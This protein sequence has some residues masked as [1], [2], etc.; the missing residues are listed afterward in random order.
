MSK[1]S[2]LLC[3]FVYFLLPAAQAVTPID[4]NEQFAFKHFRFKPDIFNQQNAK[5]MKGRKPPADENRSPL[6]EEIAEYLKNNYQNIGSTE[7]ASILKFNR[8]FNLGSQ[9]FSGFNWQ[10]PMGK[11]S[12]HANRQVQR[13][14]DAEELWLVRDTLI[15]NI[16]ATTF[17]KEAEADGVI[18]ISKTELGLFAGMTF[19]RQYTYEHFANTYE[20]GLLSDFSKL[21]LTFNLFDTSRV[22]RLSEYEIVTKEDQISAVAGGMVESPS[23]YGVSGNVG[24]L[25]KYTHIGSVKVQKLGPEDAPHPGEILRVHSVKSKMLTAGLTAELQLDFMKLV[26][27]TLFSFDFEYELKK[28]QDIGL[29]FYEQDYDRLT[30]DGEEALEFKQILSLTIPEIKALK[31]NIVSLDQREKEGQSSKF[32]ALL[33]GTLKK[34]DT[35]QIKIVKDG[36]S[37]IFFK[38][39]FENLKLVQN[40]FSRLLNITIMAMFDF[41]WGIKHDAVKSRQVRIEYEATED[42]TQNDDIFIPSEEKMSMQL[43]KKYEVRDT[44][45]WTK[46]MYKNHALE[47]MQN[48]TNLGADFVTMVR[49][50]E[51]R[52]PLSIQTSVML[53][54][55]GLKYFN[56]LN[57]DQTFLNLALICGSKKPSIWVIP[58]KREEALKHILVGPEKCVKD[59]GKDYLAYRSDYDRYKEINFKKF[60]DFVIGVHKETDHRDDLIRFFGKDN[61]FFNG[62]FIAKTKTGNTFQTYFKDGIFKSAGVVDDFVRGADRRLPASIE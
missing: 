49:K 3:L 22:F 62:S 37:K 60:R 59:L 12:I 4:S 14:F 47:I 25:V 1:I 52:G 28:S 9:N 21:F 13:Y 50:D 23:Y 5:K 54:K 57:I 45:G 53:G 55:D 6:F 40:F 48:Y 18:E 36:K 7:T 26:K 34:K 38:T 15:I 17:L 19:R 51:L 30:G 43:I 42:M 58:S 46:K 41:K 33:F 20:Q 27:I 2:F 32:A 24:A 8:E 29:S 44:T 39:Y 16:D 11:F 10:K 61:I 56:S 35:E 31:D